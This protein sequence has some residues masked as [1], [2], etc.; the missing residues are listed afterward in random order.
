MSHS[1]ETVASRIV[2]AVSLKPMTIKQ[3]AEVLCANDNSI[4]LAM[5]GLEASGKVKRQGFAPKSHMGCTPYLW[6]AA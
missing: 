2:K 1:H 5:V 4:R 3:I 6:V